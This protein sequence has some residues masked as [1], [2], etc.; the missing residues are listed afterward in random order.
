MYTSPPAAANSTDFSF[1]PSSSA[2][3]AAT[4][5]SAAYARTCSVMAI[6]QNLGPHIEQKWAVLAGSAGSVASW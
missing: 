4:P 2:S 5:C 1:M 6:E 3:S